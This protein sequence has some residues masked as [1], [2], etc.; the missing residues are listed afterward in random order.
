[1]SSRSEMN[2]YITLGITPDVSYAE[3]KQAFRRAVLRY[4]P[5][6]APGG[7]DPKRF[8]QITEAYE[9]LQRTHPRHTPTPTPTP[10]FQD[11]PSPWTVRPESQP[12]V[13]PR[14][15][16]QTLKLSLDELVNC[17]EYSENR[18]VRQVA[19]E[20]IVAKRDR[21]GLEY[22]LSRLQKTSTSEQCH[23]L[24]AFGQTGMNQLQPTL[25]RYVGQEPIEISAAAIQALERI[26]TSN[27]KRVIDRLRQEMFTPREKLLAPWH[28]LKELVAG[29]PPHSGNLGEILIRTKRVNQ[30]QLEVALL[31]QKRFPLL[32]GQ[33][34]RHLEYL[35]IAEIQQ[36]ISLQRSVQYY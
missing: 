9:L 27:R 18:Y 31:L 22:L 20:S 1:M 30:E 10:A 24:R 6:T 14:A 35:T 19:M 8:L 28:K 2:P 33:I 7:G 15:D 21:A 23:I 16:E 34:I 5:D 17:I 3:V 12:P 25:M 32:L 4:H 26:C 29:P 13:H 36:A 11:Q